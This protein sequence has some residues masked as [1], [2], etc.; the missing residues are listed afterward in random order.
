MVE[1][2]GNIVSV[3]V[4]VTIDCAVGYSPDAVCPNIPI[5]IAIGL[6]TA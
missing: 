3:A 6:W 4:A 1:E 5:G 2:V